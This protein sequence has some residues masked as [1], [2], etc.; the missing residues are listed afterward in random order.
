[1]KFTDLKWNPTGL[2]SDQAKHTFENGYTV[3]V[4]TGNHAY[5]NSSAPYDLAVMFDGK[6]CYDTPIT[7]DVL[8]YLTAKEVEEIMQQIEALPARR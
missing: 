4:I 3:S 6:L 8:G 2:A 7:D 1:M 5:G